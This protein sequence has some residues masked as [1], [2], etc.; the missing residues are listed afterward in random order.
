[1]EAPQAPHAVEWR[2]C[3]SCKAVIAYKALYWVCNVSTCTR[4]RTGLIF[5]KVSCWD[6]HVPMMN[7]R[8]SWAE[9]RK[10]PTRDEWIK[11]LEEE[12]QPKKRGPRAP[13][14]E[15]PAP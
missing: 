8:E 4:K 1:M 10:A 14:P 12:A 15:A 11:Q 3:S 7:H 2:K 6:A 9:E 5:C 13:K